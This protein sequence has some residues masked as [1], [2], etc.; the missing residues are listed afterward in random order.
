MR[1]GRVYLGGMWLIWLAKF[2]IRTLKRG[3]GVGGVSTY[4]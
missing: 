1:L 2:I 4:L 3:E